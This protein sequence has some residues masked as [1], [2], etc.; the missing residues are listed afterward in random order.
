M[1][2][3]SGSLRY[4][5]QE[6]IF[7]VESKDWYCYVDETDRRCL[8]VSNKRGICLPRADDANEIR[9]CKLDT[10]VRAAIPRDYVLLLTRLLPSDVVTGGVPAGPRVANGVVDS[11]YRG[12]INV[13]VY[14]NAACSVLP[15]GALEL[16]FALVKLADVWPSARTVFNLYDAATDYECGAEFV[17]SIKMAADSGAGDAEPQLPP[18]GNDVW[19]GTGCRA[20]VCLHDRGAIAASQYRADEADVAFAVATAASMVVGLRQT[21]SSS[22]PPSDVAFFTSGE[23]S[24][25]LPFY[26]TF[27]PKKDEDGGYDVRA[28]VS[29]TLEPMSVTSMVIRQRYRCGDGSVIPCV[30]GRSSMNASGVAVIPTRWMANEWL[31]VRLCNMTRAR[32]DI[33]AGDRIAQLLLVARESLLWLPRGQNVDEPFPSAAS[34]VRVDN[35]RVCPLP[36]WRKTAHFDEEAP[37]SERMDKGFGST[38]LGGDAL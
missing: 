37:S 28:S 17:N 32:V 10:G 13:V 6:S 4:R 30:F 29:V 2:L 12:S 21:P 20:L 31:T 27:S 1:A 38:G 19:P 11:G 35:R 7:T 8:R 34:D 14:Y 9:V 23:F 5:V 15:R 36:N 26:E 18:D 33:N 16:R 3:S 24:T 22:A 25:L